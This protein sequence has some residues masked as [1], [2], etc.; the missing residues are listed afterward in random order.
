MKRILLSTLLMG[1]MVPVASATDGVLSQ[2]NLSFN[3]ADK[4]AQNVLLVCARDNYNV[5]V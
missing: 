5:A 1:C 2:K 3:I 4:L